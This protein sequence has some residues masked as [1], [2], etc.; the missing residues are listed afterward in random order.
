MQRALN[1]P[2]SKCILC[3]QNLPDS[4][5]QLASVLVFLEHGTHVSFKQRILLIDA[6]GPEDLSNTTQLLFDVLNAHTA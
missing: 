1:S 4:S 6:S 5:L 3:T 2:R